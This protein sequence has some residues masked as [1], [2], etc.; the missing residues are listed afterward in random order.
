MLVKL[1]IEAYEDSACKGHKKGQIFA[2]LNPANYQRSF[3]VNYS[4]DMT[5]GS[6]NITKTFQ[7]IG[8]SDLN[9]SL[10]VDGT[11]RTPLA[12]SY[13]DIDDYIDKFNKLVCGFH[14]EVH[15][16]YYL[17]ITW[18]KLI[19]TGVC[20]KNNIKY[21]LFSPEGKALRAVMDLSFSESVDYKTKV[22]E[23][24]MSSPDLTHVRTVKSGDT[25][26]LMAFRIYGSKGHHIEVAKHN[27]LSSFFAIKPGDQI[28]F[29]PIDK[30]NGN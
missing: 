22:K 13:K 18:G 30:L 5:I 7:S 11:G 17:L 24:A 28:L 23:A 25:L 26:P 19:F 15:R 20:V 4:S 29:P 16:P 6:S 10:F 14:G 9:L 3:S 2:F 8:L 27:K 21:T 1:K 12:S